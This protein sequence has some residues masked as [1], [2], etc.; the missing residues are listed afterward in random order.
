MVSNYITTE[1]V[2]RSANSF[3]SSVNPHIYKLHKNS[4]LK[5]EI[6]KIKNVFKPLNHPSVSNDEGRML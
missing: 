3:H 1:W 6:K 2:N 4:F 5:N